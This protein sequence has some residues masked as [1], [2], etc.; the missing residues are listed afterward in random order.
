MSGT[1]QIFVIDLH[2]STITVDAEPT[3]TITVL[4]AKIQDKSGIPF[5]HQR[6][7]FGGKQLEDGETIAEY[8]I[9]KD[10]KIDVVSYLLGGGII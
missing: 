3:D 2:G 8:N 7:I 10:S 1:M 4:K 6:L 9:H 5:S